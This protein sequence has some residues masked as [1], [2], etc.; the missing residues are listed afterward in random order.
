MRRLRDGESVGVS[1]RQKGAFFPGSE[2]IWDS[3]EGG[4]WE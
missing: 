1:G 3:I 4:D 2:L